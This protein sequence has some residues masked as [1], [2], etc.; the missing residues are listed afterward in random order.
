DGSV[1]YHR[2]NWSSPHLGEGA[3]LHL[4]WVDR[5]PFTQMTGANADLWLSL[6]TSAGPAQTVRLEVRSRNDPARL[7]AAG[8]FTEPLRRHGPSAFQIV[9]H[10]SDLQSWLGKGDAVLIAL[11]TRD[12]SVVQW[13]LLPASTVRGLDRAIAVARP[14]AEAKVANYRRDCE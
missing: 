7:L 10:W 13:G 3:E 4:Q 12:G 2:I 8:E 9:A 5:G 14:M 11:A 6:R 1:P